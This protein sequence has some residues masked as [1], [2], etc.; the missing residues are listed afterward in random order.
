MDPGGPGALADRPAL[1]LDWETA[2]AHDIQVSDDAENWT[3]AVAVR[4]TGARVDELTFA[5]VTGRYVRMQGIKRT[6]SFGYSLWR[7]EVRATS[8]EA[9]LRDGGRRH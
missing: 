3:T 7:F 6:S 8:P 2:S 1:L 5:P 9:D 4:P